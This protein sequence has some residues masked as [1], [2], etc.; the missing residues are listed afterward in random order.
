LALAAER[1]DNEPTRFHI[2]SQFVECCKMGVWQLHLDHDIYQ[3]PQHLVSLRKCLNLSV[4][5]LTK[6][7][8]N[9]SLLVDAGSYNRLS[10]IQ[11]MLAQFN[12]TTSIRK[13]IDL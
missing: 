1:E 5:K 11:E 13:A 10:T 4:A 6:L 3:N 7:K 9:H 12:I 8:S 2:V